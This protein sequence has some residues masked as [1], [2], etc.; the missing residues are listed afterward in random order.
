MSRSGGGHHD[1]ELRWRKQVFVEKPR[2]G[3]QVWE[4]RLLITAKGCL[5]MGVHMSF[6]CAKVRHESCPL[7]A[8]LSYVS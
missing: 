7:R 8:K 5:V 2:T 6:L 1:N 3:A 4:G